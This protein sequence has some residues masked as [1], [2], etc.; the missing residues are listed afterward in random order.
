MSLSTKDLIEKCILSMHSSTAGPSDTSRAVLTECWRAIDDD[1][2]LELA[3]VGLAHQV[4]NTYARERLM[5]QLSN[6]HKKTLSRI[7][8][9]AAQGIGK[10]VADHATTVLQNISLYIDGV[11]R[12]LL[13]FTER[14]LDQ[15]SRKSRSKSKSWI[16]RARWC[17]NTKTV[18]A[19]AGVKTLG[20][21]P[22]K[23]RN[24]VASEAEKTWSK[25]PRA[26]VTKRAA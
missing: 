22:A 23:L 19:Q 12:P 18:L 25:K 9:K 8:S 24:K 6:E 4:G 26:R 21:L 15:W 2:R 5:P 10:A 17:S 13:N 11:M 7:T 14:D 20:E 3:I 16:D 1:T